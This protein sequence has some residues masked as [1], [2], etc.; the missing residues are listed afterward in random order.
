MIPKIIH[1]CWFGGKPKPDTVVKYMESW[2]EFLID[3]E[4]VEWNEDNFDLDLYPY[5]RQAYETGKFAFVTDVVRLYAL[6]EFGGI[7]MDT[8]IEVLRPLDDLLVNKGFSGFEDDVHITTGIMAAEKGN[9]WVKEQL[10]YY[11]NRNFVLENNKLDTTTNVKI[12]TEIS[13]NKHGFKPNGQFQMLKYGFAIYP[14][15]YFCPKSAETGKIDKTRNSYTI[16]HFS[17]S[18]L[19]EKEKR[20]INQYR[21]VTDIFGETLPK[22]MH[23]LYKKLKF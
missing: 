23:N 2:K 3:Y 22:K 18:W 9:L 17:G 15:D 11:I 6:L 14:K 5:V 19:S 13:T 21:L 7:Y 1:Y 20:H 12:I 16:H 10:D 8:D 4:F